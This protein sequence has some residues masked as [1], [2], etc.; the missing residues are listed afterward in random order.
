MEAYFV[1]IIVGLLSIGSVIGG[2]FL[3]QMWDA[4]Q[5]LRG[6]LNKLEIKLTK[7]YVPYDRLQ[8]VMKPIMEALTEIKEDLKGKVNK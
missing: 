2:W 1:N 8:D 6:D 5:Q 4:V 7:D 3:R